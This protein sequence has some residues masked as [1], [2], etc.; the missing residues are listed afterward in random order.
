MGSAVRGTYWYALS[1]EKVAQCVA[2]VVAVVLHKVVSGGV[3]L[4]SQ[5]AQEVLD[6]VIWNLCCP[7]R[8]GLSRARAITVTK[9]LLCYCCACHPPVHHGHG[10]IALMCTEAL[11]C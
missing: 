5:V 10:L 4:G 8:Y 3:E 1:N 11:M 7:A 2:E 6:H 9:Q